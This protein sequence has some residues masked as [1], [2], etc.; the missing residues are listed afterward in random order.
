MSDFSWWFGVVMNVVT[1][2]LLAATCFLMWLDRRERKREEE[3]ESSRFAQNYQ[4][5]Y[6]R[7]EKIMGEKE[8]PFREELS[9]RSQEFR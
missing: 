1:L 7:S 6:E 5:A 8:K 2:C 3:A 4:D 9:V